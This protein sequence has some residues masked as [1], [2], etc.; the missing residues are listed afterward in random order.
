MPKLSRSASKKAKRER[1]HEEMSRFKRGELHSGSKQ[2]PTVESRE[3]AVA[4]GLSVSGQSRKSGRKGRKASR[5]S[6]RR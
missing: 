6:G 3:Q 5:S 2:G 4:I 1:M